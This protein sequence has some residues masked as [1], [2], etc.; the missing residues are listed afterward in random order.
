MK[1]SI[2][3]ITI[4]FS[5]VGFKAMAQE[6]AAGIRGSFNL[7]NL[8]VD[9]VDD[10]N[11][12]PG[13]S[14]GLFFRKQINDAFS[15]Q[16]E[17]NYSLKGVQINYNNFLQGSGKYRYNLSYVEIPVL[18]N[19]HFGENLYIS[20]GPYAGL[21]TS[22]KI[23]DVDGEGDINEVEELD[24][25]DFNTFDYGLAAGVGVNFNSGT[26]GVRYNYGLQDVDPENE[27]LPNGKNS[28]LQLYVGFNF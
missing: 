7:S 17:L 6:D 27:Y 12:K 2:I 25:D 4:L 10:E 9:E 19:I 21:L 13:F 5:A 18:A 24:R 20:A 11:S 15:I 16:P 22:V 26:V 8:Y 28:V 14:A 1:K 23:K 3:L